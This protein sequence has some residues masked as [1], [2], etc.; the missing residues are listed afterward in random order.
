MGDDAIRCYFSFRSPYAWFA[1]E[2][3]EGELG[4]LGVP[5]E[6]IPIY[7][8]PE[9]FP[10]D[11]TALPDKAAYIVQDVPRLAR[12]LGL[13]VRFPE[14]S[15]T[16]WALPHA[17]FLAAQEQGE[18]QRF[19]IE[20]F[21]QRFGEGRDLGEDDVVAE[22]ATRAGLDAA[23]VV[24][25]GHSEALRAEASAGWRLAME[26]DHVFG[27]PTFVYADRLYWGQDRMRFVRGAVERKSGAG[28]GHDAR[29]TK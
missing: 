12:E 18:G 6:R 13:S 2:R 21:R 25:A 1:A 10:N 29:R 19:M 20:T 26:R 27:V 22:A 14:R 11:P 24:A 23:S 17:A 5:I 28:R 4:D 8:T 9:L 15:D 16:D 7:P 3:L